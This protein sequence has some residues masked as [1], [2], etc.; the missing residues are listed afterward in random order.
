M[1]N[2]SVP[3]AYVLFSLCFLFCQWSLTAKFGL[4]SIC[5]TR[6]RCHKLNLVFSCWDLKVVWAGWV[7]NKLLF[8]PSKTWPIL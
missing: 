4:S 5:V 2:I 3:N 8:N 1:S 7:G 6:H